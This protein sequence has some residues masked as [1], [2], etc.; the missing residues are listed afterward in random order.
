M[1]QMWIQ[2]ESLCDACG[3]RLLVLFEQTAVPENAGI[4]FEGD[5]VKC[6][7]CG[8]IGECDNSPE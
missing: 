3:Q 6:E 4:I 1:R 2:T 7:Y 8:R 5:E